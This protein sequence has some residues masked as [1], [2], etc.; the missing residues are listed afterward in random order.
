MR[1]G[2]FG[3]GLGDYWG[4]FPGLLDRLNGYR[5]EIVN[6]MS[7]FGVE[8][9]DAGMVD[10]SETIPASPASPDGSPKAFAVFNPTKR[11]PDTNIL[12]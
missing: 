2:I 5:Q 1:A 3:V 7:A 8:V 9:T 12:S 4:Q 11:T 10:T 6:R